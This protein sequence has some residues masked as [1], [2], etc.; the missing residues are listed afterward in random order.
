MSLSAWQLWSSPVNSEADKEKRKTKKRR[1]SCCFW[2]APTMRSELLQELSGRTGMSQSEKTA[3]V[4]GPG[5]KQRDRWSSWQWW[6]WNVSWPWKKQ[7]MFYNLVFKFSHLT[8]LWFFCSSFCPT[9][10]GLF[11]F[12][13]ILFTF[14]TK[15]VSYTSTFLCCFQKRFINQHLSDY[16]SMAKLTFLH[17]LNWQLNI[18][19]A[20]TKMFITLLN[21][22]Q[23]DFPQTHNNIR[24][25]LDSCWDCLVIVFFQYWLHFFSIFNFFACHL[26]LRG[27]VYI[28][29]VFKKSA[30]TYCTLK[31]FHEVTKG[32]SPISLPC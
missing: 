16:K 30:A 12:T 17:S 18:E 14:F 6:R 29:T 21:C 7:W 11:Y 32:T 19:T 25:Y 26:I 4:H 20:D 27:L 2:V 8:Q 1:G 10:G 5:E 3:G 22:G 9:Y 15:S 31:K 23:L 13:F 28:W 24:F